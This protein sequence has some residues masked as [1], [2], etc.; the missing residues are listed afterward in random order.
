MSPHDAN[1]VRRIVGFMEYGMALGYFEKL[2]GKTNDEQQAIIE[3]LISEEEPFRI[4]TNLARRVRPPQSLLSAF[5]SSL[6]DNAWGRESARKTTSSSSEHNDTARAGLSW[7]M[8]LA[9]IEFASVLAAFTEAPDPYVSVRPTKFEL[10]AYKELLLDGVA[11]HYWTLAKDPAVKQITRISPSNPVVLAYTRRLSLSR[12]M[13]R[14]LAKSAVSDFQ[15]QQYRELATWN[16]NLDK[17]HFG[18][19]VAIE[20]YLAAVS[21]QTTI[22]GEEEKDFVRAC[23]MQLRAE[24]KAIRKGTA[25]IVEYESSSGK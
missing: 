21:V 24:R 14:G 10:P 8:A 12:K 19:L 1:Q 23:Q 2:L 13:L 17:L 16:R 7:A 9:R 15:P 11:T 4:F 5:P 25:K 18:M 22:G 20:E 6:A 3:E